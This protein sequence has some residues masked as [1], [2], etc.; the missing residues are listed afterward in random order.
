MKQSSPK[1]FKSASNIKNWN[2]EI[3]SAR[4]TFKNGDNYEGKYLINVDRRTLVKQDHGV[5]TTDNFD[6]Y[7]GKWYDDTFG[8]DEFHIRY[9]NNTQYKGNV[10]ANGAMN[11]KGTY[12]FPDGSSL[13]STWYQNKPVSNIVCRE[14]LGYEWTTT[15][16]SDSVCINTKL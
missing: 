12:F 14:P 6:I 10:D 13:M 8:S 2:L 15:S 9:N 4:F 1:I 5:Y 16:I 7:D 3:G 11:G